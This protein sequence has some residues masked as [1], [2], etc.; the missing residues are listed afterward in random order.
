MKRLR[1]RSYGDERADAERGSVTKR[2]ISGVK[3]W[4]GKRVDRAARW[5]T[6]REARSMRQKTQGHSP[7]LHPQF[8]FLRQ[9]AI[10]G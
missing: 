3:L 5:S 9:C 8:A 1:S 7:E 2:A 6:G 10:V 4:R